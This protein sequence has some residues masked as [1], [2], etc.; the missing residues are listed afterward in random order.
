MTIRQIVFYNSLLAI[1]IVGTIFDLHH[2]K[3]ALLAWQKTSAIVT[4]KGLMGARRVIYYSY[5]FQGTEYIG[6]D[7]VMYDDIFPNAKPLTKGS[8]IDVLVNPL[9]PKKSILYNSYTTL[10]NSHILPLFIAV[11][12]SLILNAAL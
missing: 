3:K 8:E 2:R 6:Q 10:D 4:A 9:K 7:T 11:F 5:T 1:G 12:V